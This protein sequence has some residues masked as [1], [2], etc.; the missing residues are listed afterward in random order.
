MELKEFES[1]FK[2]ASAVL[3]IELIDKSIVES[4]GSETPDKTQG[5][6]NCIIAIEECAELQK[7]IT[8]ILRNKPIARACL[9]E[10]M[11]DV[12]Y[13]IRYLQNIYHISDEELIKAINVKL[14]RFVCGESCSG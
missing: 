3:N 14:D 2:S 9:I 12:L 7:V 5:F 4:I 13:A 6:D 1:K 8:K 10:E 11:G